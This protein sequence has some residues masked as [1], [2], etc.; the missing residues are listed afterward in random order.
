MK[1]N[2]KEYDWSFSTPKVSLGY[3]RKVGGV[4]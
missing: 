2:E 4:E 1:V 3:D